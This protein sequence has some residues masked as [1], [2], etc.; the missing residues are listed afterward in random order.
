[1][2][3]ELS[4]QE[5]QWK[6]SWFR[7]SAWSV[8][9]ITALAVVAR[10]AVRWTRT[11]TVGVLLACVA[12]PA[13]MLAGS[14]ALPRSPSEVPYEAMYLASFLLT[15]WL[16]A[17]AV[18]A[19]RAR[20][21]WRLGLAGGWLVSLVMSV[22]AYA[23]RFGGPIIDAVSPG[24][25]TGCVRYARG[26]WV[27]WGLHGARRVRAVDVPGAPRITFAG[28]VCGLRDGHVACEG[29]SIV[30]EP[31]SDPGRVT[32]LA[33]ATHE[34]VLVVTGD[35]LRDLTEIDGSACN[36]RRIGPVAV[37]A[38]GKDQK[39][40]EEQ[41]CV[42]RPDRT[43]SCWQSG[44]FDDELLAR[45]VLDPIAEPVYV[46]RWVDCPVVVK[47]VARDTKAIA[48]GDAHASALLDDGTL[49]T[50]GTNDKGQLGRDAGRPRDDTPRAVPGLRFA[51]VGAQGATTCG[52]TVDG[53]VFCWGDVDGTI[54]RA[55]EPVA[56]LAHVERLFFTH[57][58]AC[59]LS[60]GSLS[61]WMRSCVLP[62]RD[63]TR[64]RE[65]AGEVPRPDSAVPRRIG[66]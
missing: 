65:I 9:V 41:G 18:A 43:V 36:A 45:F 33:L 14:F 2:L 34:H 63:E 11:A 53:G 1:M 26:G 50:W 39:S 13:T 57:G 8:V 28:Q 32:A 29:S 61:C 37:L 31:P 12:L 52:R 22:A 55:P 6:L 40:R 20:R 54:T 47:R 38:V 51:E 56:G 21:P 23:P 7:M 48:M 24:D 27:C 60:G 15:S 30:A 44:L 35:T 58:C 17:D 59:A 19:R 49:L 64:L 66:L 3:S 62:L 16:A 10:L 4:R 5:A 42:L 25:D 46:G